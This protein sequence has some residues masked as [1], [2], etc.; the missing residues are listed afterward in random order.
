MYGLQKVAEG[1]ETH[2]TNVLERWAFGGVVLAL[3]SSCIQRDNY[4]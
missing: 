2:Y 4:T 1:W 3:A